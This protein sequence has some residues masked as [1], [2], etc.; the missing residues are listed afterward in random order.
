MIAPEIRETSPHPAV[1]TAE[2]SNAMYS[3][4][5]QIQNDSTRFRQSLQQT[6]TRIDLNADGEI[7]AGEIDTL[8][9]NGASR[10]KPEFLKALKDNFAQVASAHQSS[11]LKDDQTISEDDFYAIS[12]MYHS[13]RQ[14]ELL[15][16]GA[17]EYLV[18]NFRKLSER[19]LNNIEQGA[20]SWNSHLDKD[21]RYTQYLLSRFS[22]IIDLDR[23]FLSFGP[24][25]LRGIDRQ[26]IKAMSTQSMTDAGIA[27]IYMRSSG[28]NSRDYEKHR[29][30]LKSFIA[31]STK[32]L[33]G[34]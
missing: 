15:A 17:K 32:L 9:K 10:V 16:E 11:W 7:E 23:E 3:Q 31:D 25:W 5:A 19:G 20:I 21:G 18:Q 24:Q 28:F 29:D 2:A 26:D 1:A 13:K 34:N 27:A 30:G 6:F 22:T 14:D 33:F 8:Q 4:V 12:Q